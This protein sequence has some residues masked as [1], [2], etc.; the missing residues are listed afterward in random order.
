MTELTALLTVKPAA[1]GVTGVKTAQNTAASDE[2]AGFAALIAELAPGKPEAATPIVPGSAVGS[3]DEAAPAMPGNILPDVAIAELA[4]PV[5][6]D[7]QAPEQ[8]LAASG[9]AAPSQPTFVISTTQP[10]VDAAGQPVKAAQETT[11][12][13]VR[14]PAPARL[15]GLDPQ[16][17][18]APD[19]PQA[20][21][22]PLKP[23]MPVQRHPAT[24]P[25]LLPAAAVAQDLPRPAL[26]VTLTAPTA[27]V[28]DAAK[29]G[30]AIAPVLASVAVPQPLLATLA[31]DA[32][33]QTP[34]AIAPQPASASTAQPH[35]F[36]A[37]IDRLAQA[38]ESAA[39]GT[40]RVSVPH[41]EF[42]AV[43]LRFD[44]SA[45]T[46][47]V[48]M[49]SADPEFAATA[50]QAIA[51]RSFVAPL[52]TR[53]ELVATRGD[54]QTSQH[55]LSGQSSGFAQ[56]GQQARQPERQGSL[57]DHSPPETIPHQ[58]AEASRRGLYI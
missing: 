30:E 44:S 6:A 15:A 34:A 51:E 39:P 5:G 49:T 42:G 11:A 33:A 58:P 31:A 10:T 57:A 46:L 27:K 12:P 47:A 53:F 23:E 13:A 9:D 8:Q 25:Q 48:A 28:T 18:A 21:P 56:S 38:R 40:V 52:E 19:T 43:T 37:L 2:T 41:A 54:V 17:V 20:Q 3:F 14:L 29:S 36:A 32:P 55:N 35:D 7:M 16:A 26:H 4:M 22:L 1:P 45:G 24:P 50:R